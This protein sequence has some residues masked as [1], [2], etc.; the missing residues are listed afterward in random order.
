MLYTHTRT[1]SRSLDYIYILTRSRDPVY[2]EDRNS[3]HPDASPAH[4]AFVSAGIPGMRSGIP[5]PDARANVWV[6]KKERDPVS[7]STCIIHHR[8]IRIKSVDIL[9]SLFVV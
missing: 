3:N 6:L 1:P 5:P 7:N 2:N 9:A 4:L 8:R